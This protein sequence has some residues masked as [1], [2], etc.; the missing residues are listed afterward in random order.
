M[1][2]Q[3]PASPTPPKPA[4]DAAE[5]AYPHKW[6]GKR[7]DKWVFDSPILVWNRLDRGGGLSTTQ[8][9]LLAHVA[10]R[11]VLTSSIRTA[12]RWCKRH[13][14]YIRL[15]LSQLVSKG[16][17]IRLIRP[18]KR[19][20][21]WLPPM[22]RWYELIPAELCEAL[23]KRPHENDTPDDLVSDLRQEWLQR[24]LAPIGDDDCRQLA[25]LLKED[26]EKFER[27]L[28]DT[29]DR[30]KRGADQSRA[31]RLKPVDN[32]VAYFQTTWKDFA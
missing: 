20:H 11:G 3:T 14:T 24:V 16:M 1:P 12:S 30:V 23:A 18:G 28:A 4:G 26:P 2:D 21:Y 22:E 5:E 6:K 19:N 32:A 10:S 29:A 8:F 31:D 17:L 7:E 15:V 27:V 9:R 13:P 25:A